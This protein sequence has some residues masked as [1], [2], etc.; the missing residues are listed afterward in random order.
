LSLPTRGYSGAAHQERH[1]DVLL[2]GAALTLG[3]AMLAMVPAIVGGE[4]DVGIGENALV[5]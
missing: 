1:T 5:P 4:E 2:V 3:Y